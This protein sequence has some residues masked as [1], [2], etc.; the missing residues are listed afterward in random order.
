MG[1]TISRARALIPL[2]GRAPSVTP[3]TLRGAA[4]F[5]LAIR[6]LRLRSTSAPSSLAGRV[7]PY[8]LTRSQAI[9]REALKKSLEAS[10]ISHPPIPGNREAFTTWLQENSLILEQV[11]KL[12][13]SGKDLSVI[14]DEVFLLPNLETLDLNNNK[15]V[16][17]PESIERL[18]SLRHIIAKNNQ[19]TTLPESIRQLRHLCYLRLDHNQFTSVPASIRQ[20]IRLHYLHLAHNQLMALPEWIGELTALASFSVAYNH[21]TVLP[22]SIGQLTA[23]THASFAYNHLRTIPES[24]RGLSAVTH[25][26]FNG[27]SLT[28]LPESI[29]ELRTLIT[30]DL[31]FNRLRTLAEWIGELTALVRLDLDFNSLTTLPESIGR[32]EAP[33]VLSVEYNQLGTLPEWVERLLVEV[34]EATPFTVSEDECREEP[35]KTLVALLQHPVSSVEFIHTD[36][37]TDRALDEGGPARQL[38]ALLAGSLLD[39]KK[40]RSLVVSDGVLTLRLGGKETA[41]TNLGRLFSLMCEWNFGDSDLNAVLGRVLPDAWFTGLLAYHRVPNKEDSRE[42]LKA[43]AESLTH[44]DSP[45]AS[46]VQWAYGD[47]SKRTIATSALRELLY[48]GDET[49]TEETALLYVND[50]YKDI[51]RAYEAVYDGIILEARADLFQ[52]DDT[53]ITLSTKIQGEPLNAELIIERF[54]VR[55]VENPII[56]RKIGYLMTILREKASDLMWLQKFILATTGGTAITAETIFKFGSVRGVLLQARTCSM[57]LY[58]PLDVGPRRTDDLETFRESLELLLADS[59]SYHML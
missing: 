37:R 22:E 36:G 20:L 34:E 3:T 19:L 26:A 12:D 57:T 58:L 38:I 6:S 9:F 42:V 11:R 10:S 44:P 39:G 41:Y 43:I 18:S 24:I 23:V 28:A 53:G 2:P 8:L 54:D 40:E 29:R 16:A 56:L 55:A 46:I 25:L 7:S 1:I 4:P 21:L 52:R 48:V 35:E 15:F 59:A 47:T 13:L 17:L 5:D 45:D 27:N 14:P 31:R 51:C 49:P 33:F 30:L 50:R 32:L